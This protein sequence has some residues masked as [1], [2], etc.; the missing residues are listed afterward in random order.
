M[1]GGDNS[2][3]LF[4][5]THNLR[6]NARENRAPYISASNNEIKFGDTDLTILNEFTNVTSQI[7]KP[8]TVKQSGIELH[9]G[10]KSDM[11]AD[12]SKGSTYVFGNDLI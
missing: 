5:L 11:F 7:R 8:Q 1:Q 4:N 9:G 2:C 3:F 10:L 12:P 6:F